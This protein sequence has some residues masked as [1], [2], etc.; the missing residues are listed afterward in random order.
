MATETDGIEAVKAAGI[1]AVKS[2][3]NHSLLREV[4]KRIR[5]VADTSATTEFRCECAISGCTDTIHLTLAEYERIRS[6]PTSF[7]VA[8]GHD[9]AEFENVIELCDRYQVVQQR[10]LGADKR[11]DGAGAASSGANR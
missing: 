4:N 1:Q 2:A 10:G 6:S 7:A 11:Q 3:R 5:V 8:V 9:L